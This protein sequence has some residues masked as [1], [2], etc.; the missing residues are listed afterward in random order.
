MTSIRNPEFY[1]K[2]TQIELFELSHPKLY[3]LKNIVNFPYLSKKLLT[4]FWL[5]NSNF[6]LVEH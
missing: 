1:M 5:E 4:Y 6:L 2:I 3:F